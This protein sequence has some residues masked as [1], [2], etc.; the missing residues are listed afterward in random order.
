MN[1]IIVPKGR[2]GEGL[3]YPMGMCCQDINSAS[4]PETKS[5][6]MKVGNSIDGKKITGS[7]DAWNIPTLSVIV[8]NGKHYAHLKAKIDTGAYHN[9]INSVIAN[10]MSLNSIRSEIHNTPY[11]KFEMPVYQL[12]FG[13]ED[14]PDTSFVCDMPT[15]DFD[16]VEMLIGMQFVAEFCDLHIYG[17]EKKFELIFR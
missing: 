1:L 10:Q 9:H 4:S 5:R 12:I 7:L 14:V 16:E 17:K 3:V 8:G 15:V 6:I 11:G 2:R 13:F